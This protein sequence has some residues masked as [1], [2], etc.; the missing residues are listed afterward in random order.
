ML[1]ILYA[2]AG[3]IFWGVGFHID[4]YLVE[5]YFKTGSAAVLQ[6]FTA[7]LCV[8]TLPVIWYFD[9]TVLSLPLWSV[10]IMMLAGALYM[11]AMIFYLRAVQTEEASVI[12]PLFQISTLWAFLL[13]YVFLG[14]VLSTLQ[15]AG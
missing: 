9:P 10:V 14:E 15:I 11:G 3:P 8:L 2:F 6:I 7:L 1:W 12:A 5:K 4:I 13:A